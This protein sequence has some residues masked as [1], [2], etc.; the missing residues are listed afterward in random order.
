MK[1]KVAL[2]PSFFHLFFSDTSLHKLKAWEKKQANYHINQPCKD[3]LA[4]PVE[5]YVKA[6]GALFTHEYGQPADDLK[7][8]EVRGRENQNIAFW[9]EIVYMSSSN[10]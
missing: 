2:G 9:L 5:A 1:T 7:I 3:A 8:P 4:V 10:G 6:W